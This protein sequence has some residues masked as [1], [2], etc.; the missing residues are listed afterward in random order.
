[1]MAPLFSDMVVPALAFGI[2]LTISALLAATRSRHLHRSSRPEDQRAV[3]A[4]HH[5][6]RPRIGGIGV[7]A[8]ILLV[9]PL[10]APEAL[11]GRGA[12]FV[13][14]LLPVAA[15]GLAEDL[16]LRISPRGRLLAAALSGALALSVLDVW[17]WRADLPLIAPLLH[18]APLAMLFTIFATSGI[19]HAF[20]LIDGMNG[21]AGV[22]AI[23]IALGLASVASIA[24][25]PELARLAF[26][27]VPAV[28]GFMVLNF[29]MGRIF[30]GDGG[31]YALGHV[32]A[33]LGVLLVARTTEV[34]PWA[35]L[36]IFFWPV[37]DT[38]LAI[39]RRRRAGRAADQPDR[40]HVHQLVMRVLELK[41][42]GRGARGLSN[43][44]TTLVLTPFISLPVLSGI[45]LW[46]NPLAAALSFGLFAAGF[47]WAYAACLRFARR[48]RRVAGTP[49]NFLPA[50]LPA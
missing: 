41:V 49:D 18:I 48:G 23:L 44:L 25:E 11:G 6:A 22:T 45:L 8:A 32:L 12:G 38:C 42:T 40:L 26:W 17:I 3:Q 13:L 43:P 14:T 4:A 21:L 16:G 27:V 10:F 33:W 34:T 2:S 36:L 5:G 9:L 30:L 15:A 24:Q 31:A 37:A 20:N 46:N 47:V 39:W 1:M 28:A 19:C 35:I 29:P 7:V 50:L